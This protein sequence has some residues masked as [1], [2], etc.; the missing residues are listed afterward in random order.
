MGLHKAT[1]RSQGRPSS[2]CSKPRCG[3]IIAR[4]VVG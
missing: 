2:R 3:Y 4:V 1:L